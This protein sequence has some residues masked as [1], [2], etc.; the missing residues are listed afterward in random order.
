MQK[1]HAPRLDDQQGNYR[2]KLSANPYD[3]TQPVIPTA[4]ASEL[5]DPDDC[6]AGVD[7]NGA[8]AVIHRVQPATVFYSRHA[9]VNRKPISLEFN[10]FHEGL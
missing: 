9:V 10:I 1:P 6:A 2:G 5:K 4:A 7:T 3:Q 8:P